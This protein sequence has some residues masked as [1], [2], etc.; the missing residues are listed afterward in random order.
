MAYLFTQEINPFE[1]CT[2]CYT[3]LLVGC[4][5][6]F[7]QKWTQASLVSQRGPAVEAS[8]LTQVREAETQLESNLLQVSP[9]RRVVLIL[10]LASS[11]YQQI[12]PFFPDMLAQELTGELGEEEEGKKER[13]GGKQPRGW[14][15]ILY[16]CALKHKVCG[17]L[18]KDF[19]GESRLSTESI[20]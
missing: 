5:C 4:C 11:P 20:E 9:R 2:I 15:K 8:S 1:L 18:L 6:F 7:K 3:T 19:S 16:A 17:Q 14:R 10:A 13:E 12:L